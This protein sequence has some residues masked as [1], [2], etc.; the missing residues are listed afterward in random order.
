MRACVWS[1]GNASFS[2]QSK[3]ELRSA[4]NACLG[5]ASDTDDAAFTETE[6]TFCC[7][8]GMSRRRMQGGKDWNPNPQLTRRPPKLRTKKREKNKPAR[9]LA[10]KKISPRVS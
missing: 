1:A 5:T 2:P 6:Y 4:I 3:A 7:S 10:L 9:K 8:G